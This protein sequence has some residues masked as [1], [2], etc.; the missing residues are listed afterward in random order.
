M[1]TPGAVEYEYKLMFEDRSIY[2][3]TYNVETTL[4][5]KSQTIINRGLANTRMRDFYDMY[6]LVKNVDFSMETARSAFK[7]TCKKRE[8]EFSYDRIESEL[9][10]IKTSD[11]LELL[12]NNF[13]VKNHFVGELE[14][15]DV[16]NEVC[17]IIKDISG[18]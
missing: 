9:N 12:W 17:N 7:A 2:I 5:E 6:E 18:G 11:A 14:F 10:A 15:K 4:A 3:Y 1:I 13:K 8:T 16:V